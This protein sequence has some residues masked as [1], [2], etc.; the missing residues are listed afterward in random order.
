[1]NYF[2]LILLLLTAYLLIR[3]AYRGLIKELLGLLAVLIAISACYIFGNTL[4]IIF[5]KYWENEWTE[6]ISYVILFTSIYLTINMLAHALTK[7]SR[8]IALNTLNRILGA[9]FGVLKAI[10]FII[11]ANYLFLYIKMLTGFNNPYFLT[12]SNIYPVIQD[13]TDLARQIISQ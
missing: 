1:M 3:G 10:S 13:V 9:A 2:D 11:I 8:V 6:P 12:S 4:S 7:F 5:S